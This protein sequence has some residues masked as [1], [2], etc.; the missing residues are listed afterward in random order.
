MPKQTTS[1]G[2]NLAPRKPGMSAYTWL[3]SVMREDI[4]SR[5]LP[6]GTR[7]PPTRE[8]AA[9]YQLA[10]GTIVAAFE[11][12]KAEGY[13]EGVMGSGTYV[14]KVLPES[15]LNV[16]ASGEQRIAL[17]RRRYLSNFGHRVQLFENYEE[18]PTRAF[19][20]NLPALDLFPVDAWAQTSARL[21]R[22]VSAGQLRGCD[23]MGYLPLR[24]AVAD[25]LNTTRGVRCE[26]HQVAIVS[27]VQEA[28]DLS[29][30]LFV[31]KGDSVVMEDP[32]Y[33]GAAHVFRAIGAKIRATAVDHEG[34][35]PQRGTLGIADTVVS[36]RRRRMLHLGEGAFLHG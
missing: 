33:L 3:Y 12:L 18:T 27:G 8:L 24:K 32:G 29:A 15:L 20:T 25:Y 9:Q 17:P 7:L 4:L 26:P 14:S 36:S 22:E 21:L 2:L 6:A 10:R 11:Q 16:S 13:L 30:R 1:L 19:R 31:D 5:R 23:A 35:C 28:L 34:S